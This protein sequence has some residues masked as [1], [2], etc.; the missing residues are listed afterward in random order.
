MAWCFLKAFAPTVPVGFWNYD[1]GSTY[2]CTVD[3]VR[4]ACPSTEFPMWLYLA[5]V[6]WQ[7][8]TWLPLTVKLLTREHGIGHAWWWNVVWDGVVWM[9]SY[10]RIHHVLD[11]KRTS[12]EQSCGPPLSNLVKLTHLPSPR[13][14]FVSLENNHCYCAHQTALIYFYITN[15]PYLIASIFI[16]C[17]PFAVKSCN[18]SP[19]TGLW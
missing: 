7:H 2:Q 1:L 14:T 3:K 15:I 12:T 9:I 4:I 11:D 19:S 16:S 17:S 5:S 10:T 6:V 13:I 18:A 8:L